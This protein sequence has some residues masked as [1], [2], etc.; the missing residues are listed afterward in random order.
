MRDIEEMA[1]AGDVLGLMKFLQHK[2]S[3]VR[4]EAV[5]AL[6][7]VGDTRAVKA[8]ISVL[9]DKEEGFT[10]SL[11]LKQIG[12]PAVDALIAASRDHRPKVR[13]YS[14][15]A[16]G[17]IHDRRAVVP[18][19]ARLK[20]SEPSVRKAAVNALGGIGDTNAVE[21]LIVM[22]K[23]RDEWVRFASAFTLGVIGDARA[24]EPLMSALTDLS[25]MVSESAATSLGNIGDARAI[26]A[27]EPLLKD[28]FKVWVEVDPEYGESS[29]RYPV[30]EAAEKA[31]EKIRA[32]E[33][34]N[35][36]RP[37]YDA[38]TNTIWL[39]RDTEE[40]LRRLMM[41]SNKLAA[42]KRVMELTGAGSNLAKVYV[43][44]LERKE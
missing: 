5:R 27:L 6:A 33:K 44:K 13:E 39:P 37:Y 14:C 28:R 25:F 3:W 34:T 4:G 20:D 7:K 11:A 35:Q 21:P 19:I 26:A 9:A 18:L 42:V 41:T 24:V 17:G 2:D 12:E 36:S 32:K 8:L 31:L 16:L 15:E 23:D 1:N 30:R 40:E 43:E 22:L 10:A 38:Q 29:D